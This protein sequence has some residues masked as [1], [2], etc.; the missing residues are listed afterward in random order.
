MAEGG[1]ESEELVAK[2]GSSSIIWNWFGYD[3]SDMEQ[4]S[5][6]CRVCK[7]TVISK[8]GNTT[9]FF[10]HLKHQHKPEYDESLKMRTDAAKATAST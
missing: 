8:G 4:T 6:L 10:H 2:R 1:A 3:K 5:A 9:N 7:K